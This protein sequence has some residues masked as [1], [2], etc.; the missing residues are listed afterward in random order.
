MQTDLIQIYHQHKLLHLRFLN[1]DNKRVRLNGV[2]C[3]KVCYLVL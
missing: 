1:A 2:S 3:N